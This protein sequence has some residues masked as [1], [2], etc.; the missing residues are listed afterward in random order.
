MKYILIL[1]T[2]IVLSCCATQKQTTTNPQIYWVNS[3]KVS[4]TG[5]APMQCLQVQK[6][7]SIEKGKWQNFYST[8]EGFKFEAGYVYKLSLTEEKIN[9]LQVPV[10]GLSIKYTLVEVLEKKPDPKFR[11]HD[12]WALEAIDSQI[13]ERPDENDR[14]QT[15]SI[16]VNLT[17]MRIMGTDGCNN[18]FGPIKNIEDNELNLGPLGAT[19]KMCFNMDIPNKFNTAINKVSKYKIENLKLYFFDNEGTELLRFKKVD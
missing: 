2:I 11:I 14:M 4:C 18:F 12:I 13:A 17:E 8:I 1:A 15:P 9:P 10:D 16:E 3:L 6:N 7:E 19:M 5:V